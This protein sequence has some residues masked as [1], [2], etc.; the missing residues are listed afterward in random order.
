MSASV[1]SYSP[2][3]SPR[4]WYL[5]QLGTLALLLAAIAAFM[6]AWGKTP[7]Q[8]VTVSAAGLALALWGGWLRYHYYLWRRCG[9]TSVERASWL[10]DCHGVIVLG[11]A[12]S[13]LFIAASLASL[14]LA[15]FISWFYAL[16]VLGAVCGLGITIRR[17]AY[18]HR[19][20]LFVRRKVHHAWG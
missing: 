4:E 16:G 17:M 15:V 2:H 6:S 10:G 9:A 12:I 3:R 13:S 19:K 20:R 1:S 7:L 11:G 18:L 8:V 5:G 14:A